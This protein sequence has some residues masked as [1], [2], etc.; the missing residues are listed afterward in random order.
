MYF[1][2]GQMDLKQK[3]NVII[4]DN[5]DIFE[6]CMP[7]SVSFCHFFLL[8]YQRNILKQF[9]GKY[10]VNFQMTIIFTKA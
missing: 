10:E 8:G 5:S 9:V 1:Y 2:W 7:A 4:L 6:K 3:N